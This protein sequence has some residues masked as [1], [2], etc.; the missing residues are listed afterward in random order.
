M[1]ADWK[2]FTRVRDFDVTGD[3]ITVRLANERRHVVKVADDDDGYLLTAT[4]AGRRATG[5]PGAAA[6]EAWQRNRRRRLVGYRVDKR[7]R[8]VA[9]AWT[10]RAGLTPEAFRLLVRTL[11]AEADRHE[12]LLTGTDRR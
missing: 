3:A 1:P 5:D 7:G 12:L 8:L 4:V 9:Q 6:L 10:P 11:A 2:A